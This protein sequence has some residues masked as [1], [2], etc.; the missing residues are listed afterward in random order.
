M[1]HYRHEHNCKLQAAAKEDVPRFLRKLSRGSFHAVGGLCP[2][3]IS[4]I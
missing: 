3:K 1:S 2:L 4:Q